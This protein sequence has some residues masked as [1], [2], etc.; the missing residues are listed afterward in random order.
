[1]N[2][3]SAKNRITPHYHPLERITT[4]CLGPEGHFRTKKSKVQGVFEK[5]LKG[6]LTSPKSLETPFPAIRGRNL[7][8]FDK[9]TPQPEI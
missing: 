4:N 8:F 3:F 5:Y 2:S 7:R 6:I 9:N 1:M